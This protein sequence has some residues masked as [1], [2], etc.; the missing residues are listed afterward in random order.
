MGVRGEEKGGGKGGGRGGGGMTRL[1]GS[2][3]DEGPEAGVLD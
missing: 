3:G 1:E 2:I